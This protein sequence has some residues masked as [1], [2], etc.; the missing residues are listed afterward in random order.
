MLRLGKTAYSLI[1]VGATAGLSPG[2]TGGGS[3]PPVSS[4]KSEVRQTHSD[5]SPNSLHTFPEHW[6]LKAA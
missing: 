5:V 1:N 2:A 4:L 6:R 3:G